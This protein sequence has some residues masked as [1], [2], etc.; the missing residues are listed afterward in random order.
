[1]NIKLKHRLMLISSGLLAGF[2]VILPEIFVAFAWI[3]L[4]PALLVIFKR[5]D[6][7]Q[8]KLREL[9]CKGL[10]FYFSFASVYFHW[11]V[12][13][14]PLDFTG[15][16]GFSSVLVVIVAWFGLALLQALF[17]GLVFLLFGAFAKIGAFER[18]PY[19]KVILFPLLFII[20]ECFQTVG[21]WGVPW[22][23]LCLSQMAA[24][25]LV[26]TASLF[27]SYF[28]SA[29]IV[30]VNALIAFAVLCDRKTVQRR[31]FATVA[32]G[33]F[34]LNL[35]AGAILFGINSAR[36]DNSEKIKVAAVQG[37]NSISGLMVNK[38]SFDNYIRLTE[39]AA[40]AGASLVVWPETVF[41]SELRPESASGK[42]ISEVAKEYG[43][44]IVVG[45]MKYEE[46]RT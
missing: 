11:F 16:D 25:P 31:F 29:L 39:D 15:L 34:C 9:Y 4:V 10:L 36:Y 33:I 42:R 18:A 45:A 20:Y 22:G 7:E 27:G 5:V 21:F 28:V 13:L 41:V 8:I 40:K 24:L 46:G 37:N 43:I 35:F 19:L 30:A 17:G 3:S 1:M 32:L 26:Q 12:A 2:S 6:G 44:H 14:Y 38:G 23:R